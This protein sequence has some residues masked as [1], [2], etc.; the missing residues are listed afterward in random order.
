MKGKAQ[1]ELSF[2]IN[3]PYSKSPL[4]GF[5]TLIFDGDSDNIT[6]DQ[7]GIEHCGQKTK[8]AWSLMYKSILA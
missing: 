7:T 2:M 5:P 4:F 1:A 6:N 3:K 8:E